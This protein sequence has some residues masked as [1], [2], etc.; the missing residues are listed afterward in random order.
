MVSGEGTA[1]PL[2]R[3]AAMPI[4]LYCPGL[5]LLAEATRAGSTH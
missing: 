2:R 3:V 4:M 5:E 1:K